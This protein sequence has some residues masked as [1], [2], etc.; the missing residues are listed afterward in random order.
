MARLTLDKNDF[1]KL[2]D[3]AVGES[4]AP[5]RSF[6]QKEFLHYEILHGMHRTGALARMVFQGGTALRLCYGSP[7]FSEDLDFCGGANFNP[8]VLQGFGAR[9]EQM[10]ARKYKLNSRVKEP[11]LRQGGGDKKVGV[12]RYWLI[13]EVRPDKRDLPH[14]RVKVEVANVEAHTSAPRTLARNYSV[15]ADG[16][17]STF[18]R[19][20]TLE[21]IVA[22]KLIALADAHKYIRYR[23]IW[24]LGWMQMQGAELNEELVRAKIVDYGVVDFRRSANRIVQRLPELINGGTFERVMGDM[25]PMGVFRQQFGNGDFREFLMDTIPGMYRAALRSAS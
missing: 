18:V 19:V 10:I 8:Q 22:D 3:I 4:G 25:L 20:E 24:D 2:T 11:K 17:D 14:Q 16:Y 15:L 9:I 5:S 7:R 12:W 21:E 6:V 1:E 23:D 13:V